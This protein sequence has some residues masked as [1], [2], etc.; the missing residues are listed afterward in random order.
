[1]YFWNTQDKRLRGNVPLNEPT[2]KSLDKLGWF[3]LERNNQWT[4]HQGLEK[5]THAQVITSFLY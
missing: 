3:R 2:G 1:M 5:I 4:I